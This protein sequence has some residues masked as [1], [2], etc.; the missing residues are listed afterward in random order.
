[1]PERVSYAKIREPGESTMEN[2][3]DDLAVY[4]SGDPGAVPVILVHGFP[5][6]AA[7][8]RSQVEALSGQFHCVTYDVRGLGQS[9]PGNG[10]FT[11]E[12]FV[13][14]LFAVVDTLQLDRPVLGGFS[15][16]G[17]VAL[18]ALEREPGR[19]RGLILCDTKSEADND[20]AKV[21]RANLIAAI[22][23][24]G[25][26]SFAESFVPLT[27]AGDAETKSPKAFRAALAE[28]GGQDPIG[29]K[30]CLLAMACRTDTTAM[31]QKI[32]IP[33]LL[34]V[35]EQDSL[36]PPGVMKGMHER[37]RDSR[38]EIIPGAGHMAPV[39][40]PETVSRALQSFLAERF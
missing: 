11:M 40:N 12:R 20:E 16:G 9:P 37:I 38:F 27:F 24:E 8:W 35:G 3:I 31:L 36:T 33:V 26:A 28:A 2:R 25:M 30:G 22:D 14:D 4:R 18:R 1:M 7:M 23:R 5:Y 6:G 19:F 32:E 39:E 34:V 17:Y 13:E 15:M 29:V 10:Q 21:K